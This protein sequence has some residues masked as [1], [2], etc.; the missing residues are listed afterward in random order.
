[1]PIVPWRVEFSK[2]FK[3]RFQSSEND[4]NRSQ[5][6]PNVFWGD[7][8]RKNF[9]PSVPWRVEFSKIFKKKFKFPKMTKI[10]PKSIQTCFGR[11]LGQTF[12]KMFC[13]VFHGGSSLGKLSKKSKKIKFPKCP[14]SSPKESKRVLIVFWDNFSEKFLP[15]FPWKFDSSKFFEK[16]KKNSKSQKRLKS[17]P[18]V[19][20]RVLNVFWGKLFEKIFFPVF[21]GGS[22]LR[23]FSKKSIKKVKIPNRSKIVPKSVQKCFGVIFSKK[24]FAQCSMEGR[25]FENFQIFF[26]KIP[27]MPK[28]VTK[29]IQTCFERVLGQTFGKILAQFSTAGP[30]LENFEKNQKTLNFQERPKLFPKESKRV[31]NMF[32]GKFFEQFFCPVFRGESRLRNFSKKFKKCENSK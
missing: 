13:P 30:V 8:F 16:I 26:F 24:F 32:W 6:Y 25:V 23:N 11:V 21:R 7:F 12:R 3:K 28:I 2:I 29:S 10:V 1:M 20:K 9:A 22:R 14:K 19:S 17:F 31:L 4:Q 15:S 18:K 27:K 5:K